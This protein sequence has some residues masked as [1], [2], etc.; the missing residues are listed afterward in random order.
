MKPSM[1][2]PS[3]RSRAEGVALLAVIALLV[4]LAVIQHRWLG[5]IAEAER[6]KLTEEA[7][8]P[9]RSRRKWIGTRA[10]LELRIDANAET[11]GRPSA[12]SVFAPSR[13]TRRW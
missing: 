1:F 5:A 10:F 6:R 12:M 8:A 13:R 9:R 7:A 3:L 11:E 2:V 4:V